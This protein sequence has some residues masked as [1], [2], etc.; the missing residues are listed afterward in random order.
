MFVSSLQ[1]QMNKKESIICEFEMGFKKSFSCG[2][3]LNNDDIISLLCLS[4]M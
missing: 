4:D 2:F 3:N 1:L